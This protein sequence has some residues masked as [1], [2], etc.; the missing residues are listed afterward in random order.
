[1]R[2]NVIDFND[3]HVTISYIR[4]SCVIIIIIVCDCLRYMW[5]SF[6]KSNGLHVFNQH[7][8]DQTNKQIEKEFEQNI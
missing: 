1:M 6:K 7:K 8:N 5:N 3:K 4:D 2:E